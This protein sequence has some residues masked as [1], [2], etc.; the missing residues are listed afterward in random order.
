VR[1]R[2]FIT[3][4]AVIA[5]ITIIAACT[6]PSAKRR[7]ESAACGNYMCSI[8]IA[9]RAWAMDGDGHLPSDFLSM[10]NEVS[11]P[12]ILIC[13]GDHSRRPPANWALWTPN[14]SSYEIVTLHLLDG[15]TNGVFLRC[16]VHRDHLGYADGTVFDGISRRTKVPY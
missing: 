10:S 3:L 5:P 15:D 16:K 2:Q 12:R 9:A 8:C 4:V 14:Q 11:S 1:S 6:A 13:P 7:A